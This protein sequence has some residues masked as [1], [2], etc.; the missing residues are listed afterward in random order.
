MKPSPIRPALFLV[1]VVGAA[2]G[3][4]VRIA[5]DTQAGDAIRVDFQVIGAEGQPIA[6]LKA[7][8]VAI[9]VGGRARPIKELQFVKV[10]G[11][12]GGPAPGSGGRPGG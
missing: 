10:P 4:S 1:L 3:A 6:D 12:G 11:A 5:G 9:R 2:S 7:D 8:E